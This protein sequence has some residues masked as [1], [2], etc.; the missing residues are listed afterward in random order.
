[1]RYIIARVGVRISTA[2]FWQANNGNPIVHPND[3]APSSEQ[4]KA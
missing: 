3:R 1:M 2:G 4:M